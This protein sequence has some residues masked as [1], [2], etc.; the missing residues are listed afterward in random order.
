M[1]GILQKRYFTAEARSS[2]RK[3]VY[4]LT[5]TCCFAAHRTTFRFWRSLRA[6]RLGSSPLTA[7]FLACMDEYPAKTLFHR[8]GAEFTEQD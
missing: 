5:Q 8:R 1:D 3:I 6:Q 2:Q 7:F 4:C